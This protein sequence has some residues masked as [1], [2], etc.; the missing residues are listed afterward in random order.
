MSKAESTR[1]NILQKAFE[2]IYQNGYQATSIDVIIA[3]TEVTKG[4]FFYH[5]KNKEEMGLAVINEIMY[6]GMMPYMVEVLGKTDD[7]AA[8]IYNMLKGLLLTNPF[9]KV[10]YGCPAVNLVDEMAPISETF[11]KALMRLMVEW[12]KAMQETI[13]TA[14]NKGKISKNHD[15]KQ[16]ALF[17]SASYSGARNVGKIFGRGAYEEFLRQF[18][19]YLCSLT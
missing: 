4:A 10:K 15:A 13:S 3:T 17:I 8:D 18:K 9:F 7:V 19:I 6:P 16:I 5:F 1:H 14:Q 2:L 11:R 12:Q